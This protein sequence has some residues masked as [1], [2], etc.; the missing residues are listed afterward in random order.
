MLLFTVDTMQM[1]HHSSSNFVTVDTLA[2]S[3]VAM[4][5]LLQS[6]Q[7]SLELQQQTYV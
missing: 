7:D 6:S 5:Y 3:L 2:F 1:L 4:A